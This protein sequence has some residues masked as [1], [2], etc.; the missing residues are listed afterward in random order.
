MTAYRADEGRSGATAGVAA[1]IVTFEP[2]LDRLARLL[3]ALHSQ[4]GGI[5]VVDN[6]VSGWQQLDLPQLCSANGAQLCFSPGNIGLAAAFNAGLHTARTSGFSHALLLDQDSL[7]ERDMVGRLLHTLRRE[8]AGVPVAAVG[9]AFADSRGAAPP[10]FVRVGFPTNKAANP[11]PGMTTTESD[12]L[13]SSGCLIPLTAIEM[14]GDMDE[15]LFIDNVDL[16]W[17]FRARARGM[18]LLGET[19]AHLEHELGNERHRLPWGTMAIVHPPVRLYYIMR[20]RLLLY[21][22]PYVPFKWKVQDMLRVPWKVLLFSVFIAPRI[23]NLRH[24]LLGL[25]HGLLGRTGPLRS[26]AVGNSAASSRMPPL[27]H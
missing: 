19:S 8:E 17:S 16:D 11:L 6:S 23:A 15:G 12:F 27:C 22:R 2:R 25:W 24:M 13:I 9:P 26:A 10:P 4:V 18:R 21:R 14:T 7:P 5:I 20:N 1:I 3:A